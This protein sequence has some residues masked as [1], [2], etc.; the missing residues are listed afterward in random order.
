MPINC[1]A[2]AYM[3]SKDFLLEKVRP[4]LIALANDLETALGTLS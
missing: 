1:G 2:P 4:K 3:V